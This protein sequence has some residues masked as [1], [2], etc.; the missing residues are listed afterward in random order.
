MYMLGK[1]NKDDFLTELKEGKF[2]IMFD[3]GSLEDK[4]DYK[5]SR[6]I[7]ISGGPTYQ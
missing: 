1:Y 6:K 5:Y 7:L 2:K 4:F 3:K